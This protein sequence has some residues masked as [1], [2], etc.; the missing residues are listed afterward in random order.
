MDPIQAEIVVDAGLTTLK[1]GSTISANAQSLH[2]AALAEN[3]R[4]RG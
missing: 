4:L 3:I 2:G 1:G